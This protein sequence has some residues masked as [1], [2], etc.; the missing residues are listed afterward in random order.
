MTMLKPMLISLTAI[1]GAGAAYM[2]WR[3]RRPE[4]A[5]TFDDEVAAFGQEMAGKAQQ[6]RGAVTDDPKD[7]LAGNWQAGVGKVK[8]R[9][10]REKQFE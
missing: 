8:G 9:L 4:Q 5:A 1:A 10:A 7:K 3:K 6:V 2:L